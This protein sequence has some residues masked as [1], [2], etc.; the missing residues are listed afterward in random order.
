M[1]IISHN[2]RDA[3]VV[4]PHLSRVINIL[5]MLIYCNI[6]VLMYYN[7]CIARINCKVLGHWFPSCSQSCI[8]LHVVHSS[9]VDPQANGEENHAA[10]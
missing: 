5:I 6:T 2:I 7:I 10:I 8:C 9:C 1:L 4:C 3:Y